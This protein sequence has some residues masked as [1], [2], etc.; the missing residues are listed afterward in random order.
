MNKREGETVQ[1]KN[2][3]NKQKTLWTPKN[4]PGLLPA[5]SY[6]EAFSQQPHSSHS[7]Q[8]LELRVTAYTRLVFSG[9][10][11]LK[12]FSSK[13]YSSHVFINNNLFCSQLLS[14]KIKYTTS[15]YSHLTMIF[16]A[17]V[18]LNT[19]AEPD[20]SLFVLNSCFTN[21]TKILLS[22]FL[23]GLEKLN[24][25]LCLFQQNCIA[26]HHSTMALQLD[27]QAIVNSSSQETVIL[28]SCMTSKLKSPSIQHYF[29]TIVTIISSHSP[30]MTIQPLPSFLVLSKP[31]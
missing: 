7:R 10:F 30:C 8:W 25:S 26:H 20:L 19:H 6:V 14:C 31:V 4:C 18:N 11:Y 3:G 27:T 23:P 15:F 16:H 28:P 9:D 2:N 21:S 12:Q 5:Q 24:S 22:K 13:V 1:G 17:S 29:M